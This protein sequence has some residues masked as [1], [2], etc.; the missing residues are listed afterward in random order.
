[1]REEIITLTSDDPRSASPCIVCAKPLGEAAEAVFCPRC[2]SA[3]HLACW[4]DK[5]GCGKHGCRQVAHRD[6]LPSKVEEPIRPSKL[7]A[8][9][10]WS[11]V[12]AV[13]LIAGGLTWSA[14]N[15]MELRAS[16]MTVMVPSLEDEELWLRIVDAYNRDP[17]TPMRLELLYTPYGVMGNAYDQK[18]VVLIAARDGP[19]VVV[20]EPDRF[21]VYAE[22]QAL[23]P[24][25]GVLE[26]LRERGIVLDPERLQ[27]G[28]ING[29]LYGL[30]HPSREAFLVA[31]VTSRHSGAGE[32][33][34]PVLAEHLYPNDALP[35]EEQPEPPGEL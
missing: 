21:Q 35:A 16:T 8:W 9:V 6:L 15:A 19:E 33:L 12:L 30:P 22:Q 25:D 29:V 3:H 13:V 34:L 28:R 26:R 11:V 31:P 4:I 32:E 5:G 23:I 24:L 17:S 2:K 27:A 7:P 14:R 20:L 10:V 18:L 1:M